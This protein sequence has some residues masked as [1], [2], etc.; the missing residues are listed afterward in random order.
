MNI[1]FCQNN[2]YIYNEVRLFFTL[3]SIKAK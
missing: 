1:K 3:T 2:E